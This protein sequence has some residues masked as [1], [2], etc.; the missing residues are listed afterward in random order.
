M[1]TAEGP[2]LGKGWRFAGYPLFHSP[3]HPQL[4]S[5]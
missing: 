5:N 1:W 2:R 3:V 4:H